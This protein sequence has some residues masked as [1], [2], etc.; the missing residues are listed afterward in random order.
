VSEFSRHAV[1]VP[2]K[3]CVRDPQGAPLFPTEQVLRDTG[4]RGPSG[5][6]PGRMRGPRGDPLLIGPVIQKPASLASYNPCSSGNSEL[7]HYCLQADVTVGARP[8]GRKGKHM[9]PSNTTWIICSIAAVSLGALGGWMVVGKTVAK[10]KAPAIANLTSTAAEKADPPAPA[11]AEP[12]RPIT[13]SPAATPA[14]PPKAEPAKTTSKPVKAAA[15]RTPPPSE[16][17]P[18]KPKQAVRRKKSDDD[19]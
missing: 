4:P 5:D 8:N 17:A 19:D 10:G 6:R 16:A 7:A 3:G 14:P 12:V 13:P 18:A 9:R 2:Y 15:A 11:K 1:D